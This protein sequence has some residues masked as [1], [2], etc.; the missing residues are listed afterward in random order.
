MR[1]QYDEKSF[2]YDKEPMIYIY[3][4]SGSSIKQMI[5]Y[6]CVCDDTSSR[7]IKSRHISYIIIKKCV[8]NKENFLKITH[9]YKI[10]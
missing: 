3:S 6:I 9:A 4:I 2:F 7:N 5:K 8:K 10:F 1:R